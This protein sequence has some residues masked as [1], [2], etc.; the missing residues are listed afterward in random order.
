MNKFSFQ[1]M[2]G[3]GLCGMIFFLGFFPSSESNAAFHDEVEL[4]YFKDHGLLD[5]IDSS[6]YFPTSSLCGGCHGLDNE[7]F[8]MVDRNGEDINPY[9]D[10]RATMMAQSAK[11]P[12]WRA[13]VSHEIL[14]NP[15]HS[16]ELQDKCTSCHAPLGHYT[17]KYK[18][19]DHYTIDDMLV[20]TIGLDGVSCAACHQQDSVMLGQLF[21]GEI[22]F[23]TSRVVYGPYPFPFA[24]PMRDF[25][26]FEPVMSLHINDAGTCA[27]CHTLITETVDLN[28]DLTG[29]KFVE[30]ATYHEWLNSSY[31][32]QDVSCQK[33]HMP[34]IDDT[35]IISDN[36]IFLEGRTPYGLHEM[37]GANTFMLQL[38][39]ENKSL[40]GIQAT[41]ANYDSTLQATYD[42]LQ[43]QSIDLTLD[44]ENLDMDTAYFSVRV[45]NK[46]GHKFPSG[47]P[48][49]RAFIEFVVT[50]ENGDTLFSSG[51][52]GSDYEV[53]GQDP[54]AEPHFQMINNKEQVQIYELVNGDVNGNFS[55]VLERGFQGLKDNRLPP[56]GFTTDH[57][58]YDT[59][60]IIGN[61]LNDPDFNKDENGVQGTGADITRYHVPL[62]GYEGEIDLNVSFHYQSLPPKWMEEMFS[63]STTE[64]NFFKALYD[65][66]DQ[67]TVVVAKDSIHNILV[68][69][70]AIEDIENGHF[71]MY[72]NP[73]SNGE[74]IFNAGETE[75]LGVS[76]YSLNGQLINKFKKGT[77]NIQLPDQ[78]GIYLVKV[79]TNNGLFTEKISRL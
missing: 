29:D 72:P 2:L 63:E 1:K 59:T 21:S 15:S 43:N 8:A 45:R 31:N 12:F 14:V 44:L 75:I 74:V 57:E 54:Q 17:A 30:Q 38:M 60:M 36:Y 49:R 32:T 55:T 37:V 61:A 4:N 40:L 62:D 52:L 42:M 76:V 67:S 50:E 41:D 26:G 51:V 78:P 46:A 11:D 18:G 27:G 23:D 6:Q 7:G 35:V 22:N 65:A 20:D 28:G 3:L 25:V 53:Y 16:L 19:F 34:Q 73:T 69:S 79:L 47:Y 66:A 9:D 24:P 33:C 68:N 13:K 70:V 77:I 39:K 58:V 48:S 56:I 64:I 5:V 71:K 10:W